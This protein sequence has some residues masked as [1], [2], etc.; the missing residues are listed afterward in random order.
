MTD[1]EQT[2][3]NGVQAQVAYANKQ[4]TRQCMDIQ[5]CYQKNSVI[6]SSN[7]TT[8]TNPDE[9]TETNLLRLSIMFILL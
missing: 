4:W 8:T 6:G 7:S 2:R 3:L 9:S 5:N 1:E